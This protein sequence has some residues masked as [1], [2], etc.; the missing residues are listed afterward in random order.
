MVGTI[1]KAIRKIILSV[2]S[3]GNKIVTF[4]ILKGNNVSFS[5][6][7]TN[8]VP[9][10]MVARGGK[11]SLANDFSMN[12]GIKGNPI[13]CYDKCTFFVDKGAVL[14]IGE[15]V[16]MSQSALICHQSITIGNH[17]KIG[18]GVK[19]Y[20]TDFHSLDP[21][22]RASKEDLKHKVKAPVVI[23]DHAFIGAFSIILKGVTIGENSV[24]GA[25]SVVTKSIPDNQIWAGNPAKFIK[26]I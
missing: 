18:G 3:L 11:M 26:E 7:S 10:I 2:Q 20:D 22:I 16:G 4:I 19:I 14:H 5:N 6:F 12:N 1:Y 17:V 25:G 8:G 23:K 24:V 13:G 9:Y 21:K 15:Q